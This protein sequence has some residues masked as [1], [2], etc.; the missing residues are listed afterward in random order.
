[1]LD[2]QD[3]PEHRISQIEERDRILAEALAHA[4]LKEHQHRIRFPDPRGGGWKVPTALVLFATAALI[5]AF[6]PSW[7][8]TPPPPVPSA[9]EQEWGL[10]VDL[11]LQAA[12]IDVFRAREGRMPASLAEVPVRIPGLRFVRSNERVYQLVA[13]RSDGTAI[14]YDSAHPSP[15]MERGVRL[16]LGLE[17]R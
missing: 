14:V 5:A 16:W 10:R 11:W 7:I 12:Q 15:G 9:F 4:E 17:A 1:M 3:V 6:P 13:W 8:P 2:D